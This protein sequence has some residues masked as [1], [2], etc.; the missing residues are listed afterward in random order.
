MLAWCERHDVGYIV[1]IAKNERLKRLA[2][3]LLE[4]SAAAFA[5]T[6]EKQRLFDDIIYGAGTWDKDRRVIVK[7]EHGCQGSNPRFVV[8]NLCREAKDLYDRLYCARGDMENRI[9]EQQLDLLADR[10]SCH[11]W[12]SNQLRLLL[13]GLAYILLEA[14]RRL[15]LART[16]LARAQAGTIRLRLLKIGAVVLRN[17]RRVRLLLSSSYPHQELFFK[18]ALRI[19]SA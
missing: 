19:S 8:T 4:A 9:K 13:S 11:R 15:A 14:I 5:A 3:S 12:W 18:V 6:S 2:A 7:A 17:T 10:T 16:E 1:G